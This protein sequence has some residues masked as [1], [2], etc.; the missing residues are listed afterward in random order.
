M[1]AG[2]PVPI[3]IV[4]ENVGQNPLELHLRG[5]TITFDVT[6]ARPNGDIVWRRLE[7]AVTQAILQLRVL[8]SGERLE[9]AD[10]WDQR[11]KDGRQVEPGV[12]ELTGMLFTDDADPIRT[13]PITIRILAP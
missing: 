10:E 12:Y 1:A 11:G 2:D 4:A 3:V 8:E 5:R 7:G 9:M 13:R 6:A